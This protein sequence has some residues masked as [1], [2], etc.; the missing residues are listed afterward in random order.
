MPSV[1]L[2]SIHLQISMESNVIVKSFD[3]IEKLWYA[4]MQIP[5]ITPVGI[6]SRIAPSA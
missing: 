6:P 2:T 1:C 4:L 5:A 3:L